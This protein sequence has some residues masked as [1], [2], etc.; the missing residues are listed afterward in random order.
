M[1]SRVRT[2]AISGLVA[3]ATVLGGVAIPAT[4]MAQPT[5]GVR[6]MEAV[7]AAARTAGPARPAS[8]GGGGIFGGVPK[9][10]CVLATD[11]VAVEGTSSLSGEGTTAP[12][13]V[14][15][16]NGKSWK[17]VGVTLPT[18]AKSADL[19]AISCKSATS[20]LVVGDYYKSTKGGAPNYPLALLYNG[21]SVRPTAAVP[22]PKGATD[23]TVTDVSCATTKYCVAIATTDS[24]VAT[25]SDSGP[26]ILIETWN[27]AKWS[28]R[29]IATSVKAGVDA[30]AISCATASFCVLAGALTT[31]S[32]AD[33][34]TFGLYL[35]S[36]NGKTLTRMKAPAEGG[37]TD[38]VEPGAV[39]CATPA[40]C[41]V[42]GIVLVDPTSSNDNLTVT[43][44]T[45]IWNGKTWQ[46]GKVAL[47]K[48]AQS[49]ILGVSCHGAHSCET[50]GEGAASASATSGYAL[51]VSYQGAAGTVQAVPAPAK[52][53]ST[54]F[55]AVS[56]LPGGACF[57]TGWTG[58]TNAATPSLMTGVWGGK[59]WKLGPGF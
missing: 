56:C 57:A 43:S 34:F 40:N 48:G 46:A 50:V 10:S 53:R 8:D 29:T 39:S 5:S 3:L 58:K 36:W 47:P 25:V 12:T 41:G 13:R 32:G 51:A 33:K 26:D 20:C 24:N 49:I 30:N 17:N 44:F 9:I 42:T 59:S 31:L 6:P 16:W 2:I 18:G 55:T 1:R 38:L 28:L 23:V 22:L 4:A 19:E 11:C 27:G 37:G 45:Q 35:G 7:A 14:A 15:R 21:T 54:A 52:G